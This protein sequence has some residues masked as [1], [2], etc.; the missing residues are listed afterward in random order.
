M[1]LFG[2]GTLSLEG[3]D[4]PGVTIGSLEG[5][6]LVTL[7][8]LRLTVGVNNLSTVFSGKF[9]GFDKS[10][11]LVKIGTGTLTLT[12]GGNNYTGG[13]TIRRGTLLVRNQS[14]SATGSGPVLVTSGS[15]GGTGLI[16]GNVIIS[17]GDD[18][19]AILS[20]GNK[21]SLGT[22]T[23]QSSLGFNFGAIFDFGLN[24]TRAAADQ[25]IANGVNT[26]Q[27]AAFSITDAGNSV[28]PLGTV[29]T[30]INNTAA[31]PIGDTFGNL[32]D[33]G[34][35]TL[36]SNTFQANYEGGDGNDLTL[37]VVP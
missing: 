35:I 18:R 7:G 26:D 24:S 32:P 34:T 16:A 12:N 10:G 30:A 3:H 15:L 29:F 4:S 21:K 22:L 5:D 14:G 36:G 17:V 23:I 6:G 25:V 19:P 31:T 8:G 2:A 27:G 9:G 13:T 1:E 11:S 33:G 37:T 20:P 28:L